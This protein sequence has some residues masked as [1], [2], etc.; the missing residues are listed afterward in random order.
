MSYSARHKRFGLS[1]RA[2][3]EQTADRAAAMPV[4]ETEFAPQPLRERPADPHKPAR[5]GRHAS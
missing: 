1:R 4:T 3:K 5:Q 2:R